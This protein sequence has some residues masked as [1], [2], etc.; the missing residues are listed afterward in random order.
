MKEHDKRRDPKYYFQR[1]VAERGGEIVASAGL[2]RV[3]LDSRAGE[4]L[5]QRAGS[6]GPPEAGDRDDALRP[7]HGR[8]GGARS[9]DLRG[10]R[11]GRTVQRGW[12]SSRSAATGRRSRTRCPS[13]WWP[14]S[15][16][17]RSPGPP[18]QMEKTGVEIRTVAELV[19]DG[20]KWER[21]MWELEYELLQDVPTDDPVTKQPFER[22]LDWHTH[23]SFIPEAYLHRDQGR[24]VRWSDEPL[25]V[26][27]REGHAPH[28]ADGRRQRACAGRE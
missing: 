11:H 28:R 24:Q 8:S 13:S 23:P 7:H 3:Q 18:A 1:L 19:A 25:A 26:H 22:W 2:R 5:H 10:A 6:P 14:N 16:P 27:G 21:E 12:S 4:V 17:R 9:H 20:V 15:I